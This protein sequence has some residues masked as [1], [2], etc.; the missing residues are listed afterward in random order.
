MAFSPPDVIDRG[1]EVMG[2]VSKSTVQAVFRAVALGVGLVDADPGLVVAEVVA[3]LRVPRGPVQERA[4][5]TQWGCVSLCLPR[6]SGLPALPFPCPW[7][8]CHDPEEALMWVEQ[9]S[10]LHVLLWY[11]ATLPLLVGLQ[12]QVAPDKAWRSTSTSQ[13]LLSRG[14][15]PS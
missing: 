10:K 2:P 12:P 3:A 11:R 5:A 1:A 6:C 9:A 15:R 4:P 14:P 13:R 8:A 7:K